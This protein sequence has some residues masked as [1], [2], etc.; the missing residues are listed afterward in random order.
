VSDNVLQTQRLDLRR[1]AADDLDAHFTALNTPRVMERLG[2]PRSRAEL[3]EKHVKTRTSY[4]CNGFGFMLAWERE[5]GDLV[6]H[7]GMKRVENPYAPNQGDHEIGWLV[8][9]SKWR[10]GFAEEAVRAI[11]AWAFGPIG[12]PYV[13]ALTSEANVASWRLMQKLGME[14]RPDLDFTD[15]TFPAEDSP[16]IQYS[17]TPTQWERAR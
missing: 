8:A 6:A 9:D 16:T 15:P 5:T 2:G 7:C 13:V 3:A 10:Q 12:A 11:I 1:I 17:L 4:D 14:R